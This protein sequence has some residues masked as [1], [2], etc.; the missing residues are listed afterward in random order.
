MSNIP[1]I[2][3]GET[4]LIT[5]INGFIGSHIAD[6][7]LEAGYRVR[8]TVRSAGKADE[9][10][11]ALEKKYGSGKLETVIVEKMNEDGAFDEAVKGKCRTSQMAQNTNR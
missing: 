7:L 11:A 8:G 2:P 3:K 9:V 1:V 10:N 5:G 6:Q 4:I